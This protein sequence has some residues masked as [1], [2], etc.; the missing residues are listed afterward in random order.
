[1]AEAREYDP[2]IKDIANYVQSYNV[3]SELAVSLFLL[4]FFLSI[5]L[6]RPSSL[7]DPPEFYPASQSDR[8][9]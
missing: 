2:E 4:S 6:S 9:R 8:R 1:M 7:S 5:F 3:D